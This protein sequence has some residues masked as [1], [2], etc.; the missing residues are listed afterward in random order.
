MTSLTALT[1]QGLAA[2]HTAADALPNQCLV[3][4]SWPSHWLCAACAKACWQPDLRRCPRCALQL[5][6]T[7]DVCPACL[8]DAP[9]LRHCHAAVDYSPPWDAVVL[10]LKF[11]QHLAW[12]RRMA[13]LLLHTPSVAPTLA[14]AD[15]LLPVPLSAARLRERGYNQAALLAQALLRHSAAS[16][17][18]Q[19]TWL[20]RL[21]DTPAQIQLGRTAR[22]RNLLHVF[23]LEP[24]Y[25][26][27]LAGR[28]ILLVDDVMT[29]GATL[30]AVANLLLA[31]GV[32]SV[33]AIVFARTPAPA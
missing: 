21:L 30:C 18:L 25:I 2:I 9:V 14:Q 4:Q 10:Q 26:Q 1:Q 6:A 32:Q 33:D 20:L 22:L 23:A 11:H 16:A 31:H 27:Q 5:P 3:C 29:T 12:A 8:R 19:A 17:P 15:L 24:R 28:R 13:Q 7:S